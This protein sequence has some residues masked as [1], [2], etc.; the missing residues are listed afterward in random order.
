MS[1][2]PSVAPRRRKGS[3]T[4]DQPHIVLAPYQTEL[5]TLIGVEGTN[6]TTLNKPA[7]SSVGTE[8]KG[9]IAEDIS[10]AIGQS[11]RLYPNSEYPYSINENE[12]GELEYFAAIVNDE[13]MYVVCYTY[14]EDN[15]PTIIADDNMKSLARKGRGMTT[16]EA[17]ATDHNGVS[18]D[19]GCR[20]HPVMVYLA[21][22]KHTYSYG[23]LT[24]AYDDVEGSDYDKYYV[25]EYAPV[26][27][28]QPYKRI[29]FTIQ[30][31]GDDTRLIHEAIVKRIAYTDKYDIV[32]N[33]EPVNKDKGSVKTPIGFT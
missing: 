7:V 5:K 11:F 33:N 19:N 1:T 16:G 4:T 9:R 29:F 13:N 15:N 8:F 14:D 3:V 6:P 2:N 17:E 24:D 10:W 12:D 20:P 21:R 25:I 26:R 30:N 32:V 31:R 28:A 22:S 23:H 18:L 27:R